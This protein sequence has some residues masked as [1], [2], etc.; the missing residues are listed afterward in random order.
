MNDLSEVFEE[1]QVQYN[2]I[3]QHVEHPKIGTVTLPAAPIKLN[4]QR[5]AIHSAPPMLGEHTKELLK[6]ILN[7]SDEEIHDLYESKVIT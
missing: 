4:H 3:V 6:D 1:P 2:Q 7:L 5:P